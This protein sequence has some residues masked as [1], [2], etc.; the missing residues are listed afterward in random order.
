MTFNS[1]DA[2]MDRQDDA[3]EHGRIE[4]YLEGRKKERQLV[5]YWVRRWV[6]DV[7]PIVIARM[8]EKGEHA[9]EGFG[10]CFPG[11]KLRMKP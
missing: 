8:I 9:G 4:G 5:V 10:D 3:H 11:S 2:E 1:S 7:D 6:G